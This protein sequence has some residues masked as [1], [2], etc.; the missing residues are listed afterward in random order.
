MNS[1]LEII[2]RPKSQ[3]EFVAEFDRFLVQAKESGEGKIAT[4]FGF[5]WGNFMYE[6]DWLEEELTPE[7]IREKVSEAEREGFGCI[8]NS[9]LYLTKSSSGLR[10]TFCHE[11]DIHIEGPLDSEHMKIEK[12]RYLNL[13][14]D[15]S[16]RIRQTE[17]SSGGNR[18]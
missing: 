4:M 5:A 12:E 11:A 6:R 8:G 18:S 3:D 7:E 17:P 1:T 9:D 16:E 2:A 13:E 10:Y 14:W 15:V